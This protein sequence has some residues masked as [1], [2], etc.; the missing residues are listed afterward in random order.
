MGKLDMYHDSRISVLDLKEGLLPCLPESKFDSDS[1]TKAS[2]LNQDEL[3]QLLP[4]LL[5]WIQDLN[6]P[7]AMEVLPLLI[8]AEKEVIPEIEW[9]LKGKDEIWKGNC[10]RC[11]L[12]SLSSE[13]VQPLVPHLQRIAE[14][15]TKNELAEE[16]D[17]DAKECIAHL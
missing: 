17:I 11:V 3:K 9:V 13:V 15:P 10:I 4:Y 8:S 16:T 12:M 5:S 7:I 14:D 2:Q 6:W 1:V